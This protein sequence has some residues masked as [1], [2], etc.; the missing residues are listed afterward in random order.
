VRRFTGLIVV[1]ALAAA[2]SGA[3]EQL[4]RMEH[5]LARHAS[6]G[7]GASW[8]AAGDAGHDER[9]CAVCLTLH[10]PLLSAGYVPL[11]ICLGLWVQ[12]LTLLRPRLT[13]QRAWRSIDCRG[14]PL[15]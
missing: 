8:L 14:P 10:M 5:G 7:L 1:L 9:N 15:L 12:F 11:L 4:H 2:G 3:M 6:R 13:P